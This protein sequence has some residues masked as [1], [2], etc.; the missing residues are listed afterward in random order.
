M[1]LRP[2]EFICMVDRREEEQEREGSHLGTSSAEGRG[3]RQAEATYFF[4]LVRAGARQER[5]PVTYD[6]WVTK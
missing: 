6:E 5:V 3:E 4:Y 2:V 1:V